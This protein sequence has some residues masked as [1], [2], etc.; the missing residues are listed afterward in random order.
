MGKLKIRKRGLMAVLSA[1]K[2]DVISAQMAILKVVFLQA[3]IIAGL[4]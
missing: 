2:L 1:V 3:S 4:F